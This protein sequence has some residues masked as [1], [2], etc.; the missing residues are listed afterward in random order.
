MLGALNLGDASTQMVFV[1]YTEE[2]P[3]KIEKMMAFSESYNLSSHSHLCYWVATIQTH[4]L[5]YLTQGSDVQVSV[6]GDDGK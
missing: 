4:Y 5:A 3:F 6:D 1:P 2:S